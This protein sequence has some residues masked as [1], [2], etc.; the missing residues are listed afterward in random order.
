MGR[1]RKKY[2]SAV[3]F[4]GRDEASITAQREFNLFVED[5]VKRTGVIPK[6][7]VSPKSGEQ[8]FDEFIVILG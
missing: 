1:D 4:E 2:R 3:I 5:Y 6:T 7:V 8:K